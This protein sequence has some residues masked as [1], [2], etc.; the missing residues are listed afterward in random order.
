M[1]SGYGSAPAGD[2]T[3]LLSPLSVLS[4]ITSF[5]HTQLQ[6]RT[7]LDLHLDDPCILSM[8]PEPR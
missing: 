7:R 5:V 1:A 6:Y 2:G 3:S 8:V 4:C